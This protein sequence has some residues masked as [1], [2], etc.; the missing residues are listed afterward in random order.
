MVNMVTLRDIVSRFG[1]RYVWGSS[2]DDS[3]NQSK[4]ERI[5]SNTSLFQH[6]TP[7]S[8]GLDELRRIVLDEP[9]I[10]KAIYKKN[11]DTFRNWFIIKTQD[12]KLLSDSDYKIIKNFDKKT[13][14][15]YQLLTS[16]I[17]ANMYGTGF[18]EKIYNEQKGTD[19]ITEIT[20]RKKLID[21]R[22]LNSEN[23][24]ERKK[25]PHD[26][27]DPILYPVYKESGLNEG[28]LIHPSRLEVVRI[29]K[30][31][32]SY[33]GISL[34]KIAWNIL[35][36]K[37]NADIGSGELLNWYGRGMYD[38]TI[39]GMNPDDEKHTEKQV[40]KHPDYLIH[41]EKVGL[42]VVNPTRIDP[43]PFYDYFYTN[44]AAVIMMP[45]QM[46]IGTDTG[47]VTGS[48]TGVSAYYADIESIQNLIFTPIIT[49]IYSEL[50]RS[51]GKNWDYILEWNP[52]NVD[53]MSEAKMLQS[54]AYS[55]VQVKN[56]GVVDV[57]EARE[58][59]NVGLVN[60]DKDKKIIQPKVSVDKPSDPNIEPQPAIKR[61]EEKHIYKPFLTIS[62]R[63]MIEK[64]KVKGKI[65][66]ELQEIRIREALGKKKK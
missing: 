62:D 36:S 37:M 66:E 65:E 38:I 50:F 23:I 6:D 43:S 45:K 16:G 58:I 61:E 2:D 47:G 31:P 13:N 15:P 5:V 53:E 32:Y 20:N 10:R 33:F 27:N 60:L 1:R 9:L 41:D 59:L 54:R 40:K 14:F 17:C 57:G 42:S 21:I 28:R 7:D 51:I 29:D 22:V 4:I 18:L 8:V 35:K 12:G 3:K 44:I 49:N 24:S 52:T 30:L 11:L 46:L 19:P 39:Q 34:V 63:E 64:M 26:D 25:N 55:A 48:E 56:A